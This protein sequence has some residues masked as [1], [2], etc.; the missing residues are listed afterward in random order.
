MTYVVH[1][2]WY[3]I[4]HKFIVSIQ[5]PSP[6]TPRIIF[7]DLEYF[8]ILNN[9]Y[10]NHHETHTHDRHD[11]VKEKPSDERTHSPLPLL[12]R[13]REW[14]FTERRVDVDNID[15]G[16]RREYYDRN[17]LRER[18]Y[19]KRHANPGSPSRGVYYRDWRIYSPGEEVIANVELKEDEKRWGVWKAERKSSWERWLWRRK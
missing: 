3:D 7:I 12:I 6:W 13:R 5:N 11:N 1:T 17:I 4:W 14:D 19:N 9:T 18:E 10:N 15:Q 16:A 2:C 8:Q